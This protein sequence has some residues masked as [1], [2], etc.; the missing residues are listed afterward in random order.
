[1]RMEIGQDYGSNYGKSFFFLGIPKWL[2][3]SFVRFHLNDDLEY[4]SRESSELYLH[5]KIPNNNN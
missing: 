3:S 1:M 4:F 5:V 2:D